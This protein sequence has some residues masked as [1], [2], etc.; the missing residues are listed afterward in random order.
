M[1]NKQRV[2][3]IHMLVETQIFLI[4][5]YSQQVKLVASARASLGSQNYHWQLASIN[6]SGLAKYVHRWA[7]RRKRMQL[8]QLSFPAHALTLASLETARK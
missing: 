8:L 6:S 7:I 3:A 4:S 2:V 5:V 1:K